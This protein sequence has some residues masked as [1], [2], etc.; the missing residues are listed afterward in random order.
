MARIPTFAPSA[1]LTFAELPYPFN[2]IRVILR[3]LIIPRQQSNI[4]WQSYAA[5]R[6]D[7]L[8]INT[9]VEKAAMKA[10][11]DQAKAQG[12]RSP[13]EIKRAEDALAR[14]E[15][16]QKILNGEKVETRLD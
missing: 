13:E 5:A 2:D 16:L 1:N 12:S 15:Q 7:E 4:V 10:N 8:R 6:M 3:S 9:E 11:I 14:I